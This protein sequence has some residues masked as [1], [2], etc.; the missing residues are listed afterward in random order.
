MAIMTPAF[1]QALLQSDPSLTSAVAAFQAAGF[2]AALQAAGAGLTVLAPTNAAFAAFAARLNLTLPQLLASPSLLPLLAFHVLPA[3]ARAASLVN[4]AALATASGQ[5][6]HVT[7]TTGA[8]YFNEALVDTADVVATNGVL[9]TLDAVMAPPNL[10]F[11]VAALPG[12][13]VTCPVAALANVTALAAA[14]ASP[15]QVLGGRPLP[16]LKEAL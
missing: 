12:A 16:I 10:G 1:P 7:V 6:V 2:T 14:C 9:Y 8:I 15:A 11:A 13:A 4:G 3:P 5:S